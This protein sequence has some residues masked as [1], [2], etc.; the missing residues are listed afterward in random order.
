MIFD[1]RLDTVLRTPAP[2]IAAARIRFRQLVDL[3]GRLPDSQWTDAHVAA[4]A[5]LDQFAES[6]PEADCVRI[7]ETATI[8]SSRLVRHLATATARVAGATMA[9]AC[10]R[11][12]T[13]LA[14][15]P[16]LPVLARGFLRHRRDLPAK[17]ESLLERLGVGD[18][19]LPHPAEFAREGLTV[20]VEDTPAETKASPTLVTTDGQT[21]ARPATVEA[22][23]KKALEEEPRLSG[24]GAIV[25]RIEAFRQARSV[26]QETQRGDPRLPLGDE[27]EQRSQRLCE[28]QFRTDAEGS[29]VWADGPVQS[30]LWGHAPFTAEPDAPARCDFG[31]LRAVR[32]R[33]PIREGRIDLEGAD[34]IRGAWRVDAIPLFADR[35]GRFT[36]YLGR[37]RRPGTEAPAAAEGCTDRLRQLLHEL[38]T[39][40]NAIQGF[41]ELIQQQ[42]FGPTPH[43]Y[44][45]L[46]ASI[47]SD[48]ARILGGFDDIDR[49]VKLETGH[50]VPD[51]G[52]ADIGAVF[53]RLMGQLEQVVASREVRLRVERTPGSLITTIDEIELERMVW[54]VL[55]VIA[56]AAQPGERFRF[57]L[58]ED[59]GRYSLSLPLP[60]ALAARTD[61]D[62]FAPDSSTAAASPA[63]AMLGSGFALRLAAAEARGMGGS[64]HRD[65]ARLVLFLPST[66]HNGRSFSQTGKA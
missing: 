10:L 24:I 21:I 52:T 57:V 58:T 17:V 11:E 54:R 1:D 8:R 29:V 22:Q 5:H 51:A 3:L 36:G 31:T 19:A 45:S 42:I 64:L 56:S 33:T 12:E 16:D 65:G 50:L 34:L 6:L 7:I 9:R 26:A 39:P 27:H 35:G 66:E 23:V 20:E 47:A 13:W 25:R 15:I 40:V 2:G 63:T 41:A 28:I 55:T 38:R 62:L 44:R 32:S 14:I 60:A 4:L 46:A 37:L 49:M 48:A 59:Q 53:D 61:D 18:F 43:E 30:L